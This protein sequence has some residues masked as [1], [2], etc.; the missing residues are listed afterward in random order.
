MKRNKATTAFGALLVLTEAMREASAESS[1]VRD[2]DDILR[3]F[4]TV[5][6]RAIDETARECDFVASTETLD[7]HGTIFRQN[8]RF[9][10]FAKNP[11][12]LWAHGTDWAVPNLPIG[13]AVRFAVEGGALVIRVR[14]S[15]AKA[16]P[17]AE[18]CWQSVLE[19]VLRGGSIR[20]RPGKISEE[21]IGGRYVEVYD[22]NEL[23]EFSLCPIPSNPDTV[24]RIA[25]RMG[26]AGADIERAM[27]T[28]HQ[29]RGNQVSG[30]VPGKERNQMRRIKL[31]L[32]H[33][34][35][36][37]LK[38][39]TMVD[40]GADSVIVESADIGAKLAAAD[41]AA[42]SAADSDA[43]ATAA[44]TERDAARAALAKSEE[45][46]RKAVEARAELELDALG[47]KLTQAER[48]SFR[49]LASK[50]PE[51]YASLVAGKRGPSEGTTDTGRDVQRSESPVP[52]GP[53][54]PVGSTSTA[55]PVGSALASLATVATAPAGVAN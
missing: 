8:W 53:R 9:E 21:E 11:V 54:G 44:T 39:Y 4:D 5:Q 22:D 17:F 14:F 41:A 27:G 29:E 13:K 3:A 19:D 24:K 28:A 46:A 38:G 45:T 42:R 48:V 31:Q 50:A 6:V 20:A 25:A 36:L 43:R 26:I 55:A 1:P 18:L 30:D 33:V 47:D 34:E 7:S 49:S 10:R 40:D 52:P 16:N 51:E 32:P 35:E 23:I 2:G 12:I 37:R 15:S